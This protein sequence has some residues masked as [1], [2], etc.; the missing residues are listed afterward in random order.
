[1]LKKII[2]SV[3]LVTVIGAGGTALAY[4]V[5]TQET[6]VAAAIPEPPAGGQQR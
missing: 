5:A 1:M 4:N 6:E 3:L 2:V